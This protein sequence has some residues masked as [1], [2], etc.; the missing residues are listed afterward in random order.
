MTTLTTAAHRASSYVPT[1]DRAAFNAECLAC[2]IAGL[3]LPEI[4]RQPAAPGRRP[5]SVAEGMAWT[6]GAPRMT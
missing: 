1:S 6:M 4:V 5:S 2:V 3:P